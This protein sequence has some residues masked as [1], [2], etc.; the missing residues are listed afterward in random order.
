MQCWYVKRLSVPPLVNKQNCFRE[1]EERPKQGWWPM[2]IHHTTTLSWLLSYVLT[3]SS[4][5]LPN[6]T[7]S[8][9]QLIRCEKGN[10]MSHNHVIVFT[11]P[12]RKQSAADQMREEKRNGVKTFH[13]LYQTKP[14]GMSS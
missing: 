14:K 9:Q 12:N 10:K 11:K 8:D 13:R 3:Y 6:Q 7:S 5:F 4:H 1:R 2:I